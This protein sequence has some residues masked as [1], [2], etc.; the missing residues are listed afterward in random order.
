V[1]QEPTLS[2]RIHPSIHED[3]LRRFTRVLINQRQMPGEMLAGAVRIK[4]CPIGSLFNEN[5]MPRILF[6][7]TQI[8]S[9][10]QG[11][12]LRCRDELAVERDNGVNVLGFDKILGDGLKHTNSFIQTG[13]HTGRV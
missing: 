12:F 1:N 6:I 8:I 9:N 11:L 2:L 7:P 10:T 3:A 5:K 4:C 13:S